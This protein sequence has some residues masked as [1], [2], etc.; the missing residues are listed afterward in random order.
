MRALIFT[1]ATLTATAAQ[2]G[3][4]GDCDKSAPRSAAQPSTGVTRVVIVGRAGFL[5]IEGHPGAAEV[6][7]TGTACAEDN[8]TLNDVK[9][10]GTRSGS[11]VRIE[12]IMPRRDNWFGSSPTLDFTVSL[13]AGV[14]VDVEDSSG[15][16]TIS[17]VGDAK[18]DD[19]SG[20]IDIRRVTGNLTVRDS[21]GEIDIEDVSG[22]VRIPEDGSGSIRIERVGGSVTIDEDGSGSIE[23]RNVKRNV[24]IGTD[25]SGGVEVSEVGGDFSVG[26]KGSGSI[27]YDRINGRVSVP[28][29]HHRR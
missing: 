21:S 8:D 16:L 15:E 1:L 29:R 7:A 9:L 2:A 22:D 13:P 20:S 4:F 26:S 10:S 5:H 19:S 3:W 12:A 24:T 14:A 27:D 17:N 28:E 6:R 11:E 23:I 25:G 18:V